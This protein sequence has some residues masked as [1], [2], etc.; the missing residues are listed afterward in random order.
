MPEAGVSGWCHSI[1][2]SALRSV[3]ERRSVNTGHKLVFVDPLDRF[4]FQKKFE[5]RFFS[6]M[7]NQCIERRLVSPGEKRLDF[8]G[9]F[10]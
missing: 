5:M 1:D 3:D 4:F 8:P 7:V 6:G 2:S 10:C 9:P